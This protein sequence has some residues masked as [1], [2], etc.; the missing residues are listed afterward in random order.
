ME[1]PVDGQ[2]IEVVFKGKTKPVENQEMEIER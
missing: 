2:L 1:Y